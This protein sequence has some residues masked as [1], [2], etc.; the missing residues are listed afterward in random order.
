M[1]LAADWT[2]DEKLNYIIRLL[3]GVIETKPG[4]NPKTLITPL[5]M[6]LDW[7]KDAKPGFYTGIEIAE[8]CGFINIKPSTI[9]M[10]GRIL[11]E[12]TTAKR[13]K[14]GSKRGFRIA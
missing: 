3:E 10:V 7:F 14:S 12:H 8:Q 13:T 2:V 5:S 11:E 9:I 1:T 6:V 4:R